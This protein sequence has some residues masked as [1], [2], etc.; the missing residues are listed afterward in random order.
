MVFVTQRDRDKYQ[1]ILMYVT[2][3]Y[4]RVSLC[5]KYGFGIGMSEGIMDLRLYNYVTCKCHG[6]TCCLSC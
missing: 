1:C 5:S 2:I 6:Q 4:I 3:L